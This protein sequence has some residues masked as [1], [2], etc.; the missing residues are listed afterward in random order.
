[1]MILTKESVE[2]IA[3]L[4]L[5]LLTSGKNDDE[6]NAIVEELRAHLEEAESRGKNI[7]NVTGDSPEAYMASIR[8]EMETDFSGIAKM[9][10]MFILLLLAYF[11]TGPAIRGELSFSILTLITYPL[12]AFL[13]IGAYLYF[14]RKMSVK[15]W[16]TKREIAVFMGIQFTI[17]LLFA[18]LMFVDIFFFEPFYIPSRDIAWIIAAAGIAVFIVSALW[19]KSWITIVLPLLLFGPDFAMQFIEV[20][21]TRQL[22][23]S[24]TVL[25]AGLVLIIAFLFFQNKKQNS[26]NS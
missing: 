3:N 2:F 25:Y 7:R 19:N 12:I 23:I 8:S 5:Y 1:M 11:L 17:V 6:I 10:P 14:F 22:I 26:H 20:G 16:S 21:Q 24:T 13:G 9:M 4:K 18:A 15:Q